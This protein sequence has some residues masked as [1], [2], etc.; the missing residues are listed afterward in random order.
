MC[1]RDSLALDLA[2]A[3]VGL[4]NQDLA[5]KLDQATQGFRQA[6]NTLADTAVNGINQAADW[7]TTQVDNLKN[8][9]Q[10]AVF[11]AADKVNAGLEAINPYV[12]ALEAAVNTLKEACLLYTSRCV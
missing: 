7:A 10:D 12:G 11:A 1:I 4:I 8:K 2:I 3:A 5:N 9:A 6:V